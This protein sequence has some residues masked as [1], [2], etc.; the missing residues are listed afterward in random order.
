MAK[1]TYEEKM[2]TKK[3][4]EEAAREV[5]VEKGIDKAS[6]REIA[7]RAGVGASTLYG[8]FPSKTLLFIE[9]I[10]PSIESQQ[11]MSDTL[12]RIDL[13]QATFD[14]IVDKLAEAVFYIP[15][16]IH[17]FDREVIRQLH[18]LIFAESI[19]QEDIRNHMINIME[20]QVQS[21]LT[22]FFKRMLD[23][24]V[25]KVELDPDE[26]GGL[27]MSFMRLIFLE[28][29]IILAY[30]KEECFDRLRNAIRL[31]LIGKI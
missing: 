10:M 1:I 3:R 30:S 20:E 7:K 18:M 26:M 22:K 29:V 2:A 6:I 9:T 13:S 21:V 17:N 27:L 8:Y 12:D 11:L 28:Y 23:E 15:I 16:S 4:I 31:I 14:E 19:T 24:R 25:M 5:L